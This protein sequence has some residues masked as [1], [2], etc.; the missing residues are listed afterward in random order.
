MRNTKCNIYVKYINKLLT[1]I[2]KEY[3]LKNMENKTLEE[4]IITAMDDNNI[5]LIKHLPYILQDFWE[6]GTSPEEIIKIIRKYMVNYSDL[7]VLDLGSGKGAVS[8]KI[9]SE[10]NCKCFGIDGID[11]FV[12]FSNNKSKEYNVNN[13]C[14]FETGD[15]RTKIKTLG[16]YDIIILGAI[17]N[18]FG[19]YYETLMKLSPHINNEGLIIIDDAFVEDNCPQEYL[20]ILQ[21]SELI[22][23]VNN[24]GMEIIQIITIEDIPE[25]EEEYGYEF[26]NIQKRC[27]ELIEK[28]PKDKELLLG[29]IEN[30]RREYE[31]LSNEIIP[32]MFVIKKME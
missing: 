27:M 17:G 10:L 12:I 7:N 1:K 19:N 32:A 28:Y 16:K 23:Q 15:I 25:T 5:S 20:N 22:N 24:A 4:S 3:I 29:Y 9:A 31:I 8:I 21:K 11:D 6:I 18:V 13:I 14:T 2:N 30:Q 26:K